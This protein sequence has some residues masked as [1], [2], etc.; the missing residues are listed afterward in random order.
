LIRSFLVE[1][2]YTH[3]YHSPIG[4]L[5]VGV[6][7]TGTVRRIGFDDFRTR[8]PG[9]IWSVNKYACGEVEYQLEE[10]FTGKRRHFTVDTCVEGTDFQKAVWGRLR[11]VA[12]GH[13]LSYSSLARKIGRRDAARAVGQAVGANPILIVIP[14]H[15]V[16][17]ADGSPGNYARGALPEGRGQDIKRELLAL[18]RRTVGT[19]T[20]PDR[21]ITPEDS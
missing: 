4:V 8:L 12:Y 3:E 1:H 15:R 13:T 17:L 19:G 16:V 6:D 14:C 20:V 2:L 21:E 9:Q 18:E 11:K 7:Q 5:Y 10:Y